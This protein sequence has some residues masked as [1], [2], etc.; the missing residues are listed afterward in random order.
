MY[1]AAQIKTALE[2]FRPFA[3]SA[4][5]S[6]SGGFVLRGLDRA[7]VVQL[8]AS[9]GQMVRNLIDRWVYIFQI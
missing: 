9:S 1:S 7:N 6:V 5:M 4:W 2:L 3:S 8:C